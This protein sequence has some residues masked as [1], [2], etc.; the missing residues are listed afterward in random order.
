MTDSFAGSD[1]GT[2][3]A[4]VSATAT[5]ASAGQPAAD[6]SMPPDF[7]RNSPEYR[8][9]EQKLR[10]EARARGSAEAQLAQAREA[11]ETQRQAAEAAAQEAREREIRAV[12]GDDGVAA[13]AQM[14]E[15]SQS[16]PIA[17]ARMLAEWR[18]GTPPAAPAPPA[19]TS[20]PEGTVTTPPV[21][22][23]P[24]PPAG[25]DA[26]APLGSTST[27]DEYEAATQAMEA[28]Y[29]E[30]VERIQNPLTR[31]RVRLRDQARGFYDFVTASYFKAGARPNKR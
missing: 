29:G 31:N 7:V 17:A 4:P 8:A 6:T 13:W 2:G 14:A 23:T 15:L 16:D 12:L 27:A 5:T 26:A 19:A 20:Q 30:I 28:E 18:K 24:P 3:Q 9:L 11:A 25:L 22:G 10:A 21:P 1:G